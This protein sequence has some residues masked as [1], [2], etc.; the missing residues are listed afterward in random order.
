MVTKLA[1]RFP[2]QGVL[3]WA[4]RA[5]IG[6]YRAHLGGLLGHS[7]LLL[8]HRGRKTGLPRQ[9]VLEVLHYDPQT[10]TYVVAA[11]WGAQTD[12]LRNIQQTPDVMVESG[13]ERL[14]ARAQIL[15][16]DG[17]E[18]EFR[19]YIRH[20]PVRA[21][22]MSRLLLGRPF[23]GADATIQQLARTVPLVALRPR[24]PR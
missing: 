22:A 24:A 2:V 18:R 17:A 21:R 12:W 13:R 20:H 8:T 10:H 7:G 6:L 16:P 9:T 5:P 14:L 11:G 19:Y 1:E 4:L 23:D 15:T 3:R